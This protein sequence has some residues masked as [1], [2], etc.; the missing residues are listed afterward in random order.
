[1]HVDLFVVDEML[2]RAYFVI[3]IIKMYRTVENIKI[4]GFFFN[5][6]IK[7]ND[8]AKFPCFK[9]LKILSFR[10]NMRQN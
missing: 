2:S 7:K 9:C 6:N 4:F 8:A 5:P 10:M 1:M 3:L